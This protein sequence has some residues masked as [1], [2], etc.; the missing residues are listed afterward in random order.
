MLDLFFKAVWADIIGAYEM[1]EKR[2]LFD[3]P[4]NVKRFLFL[5]YICLLALLVIDPF[6]HKHPDFE[7]EAAPQFFAAYGFVSCVLLIFIARILRFFLK[8]DEDYYEE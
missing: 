1:N 3:S 5:F 4:V 6:I 7:W 2:S 8:R